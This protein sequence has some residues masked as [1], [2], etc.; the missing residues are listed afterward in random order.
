MAAD[1]LAF[2]VARSSA[3]ILLTMQEDKRVLVFHKEGI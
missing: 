3:A 2:Y 1:A